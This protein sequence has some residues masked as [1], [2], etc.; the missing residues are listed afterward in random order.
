[1]FFEP[2]LI[3][4]LLLFLKEEEDR[5]LLE[6]MEKISQKLEEGDL[7]ISSCI[8]KHFSAS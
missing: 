2:T 8:D 4:S 6:E 1:M 5:D 7:D 3:L